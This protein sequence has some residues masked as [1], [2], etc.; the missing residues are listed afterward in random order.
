MKNLIIA[1]LIGISLFSC[2]KTDSL[3]SDNHDYTNYRVYFTSKTGDTTYTPTKGA[4]VETV[5]LDSAEDKDLKAVLLAYDGH[6]NYIIS[7]TSNL[8]CQSI[9]RWGW[10][11]LTI[12]TIMPGGAQGDVLKAGETKVFTLSGSPKVGKIKLQAQ[13]SCGNS[14]TLIINITTAILPITYLN[15]T[16]SYNNDLKKHVINFDIVHPQDV[17]WI[18]IEQLIGKEYKLIYSIPGDEITT[19]YSIK[20]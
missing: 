1:L 6:G 3:Q 17:N 10:E 2:K 14:S 4:R 8:P 13:G 19:K 5:G 18:I 9:I 20:L 12:D 15:Y 16:V 7:V 11:G